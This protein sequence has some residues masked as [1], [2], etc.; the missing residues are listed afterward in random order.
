MRIVIIYAGNIRGVFR[1]FIR[2]MSQSSFLLVGLVGCT[3]D[4]SDVSESTVVFV[5]DF[6]IE[7]K[8]C[9]VM[10]GFFGNIHG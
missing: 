10:Y 2:F 1:L 5:T 9:Y 7:Y 3:I 6:L 8:V 4:A